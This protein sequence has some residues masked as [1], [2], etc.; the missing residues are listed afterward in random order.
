MAKV[1]L[2]SCVSKKRSEKSKA[3]DLY[4]SPLFKYNLRYAQSMHPD[5]IFILSAEYGL[6]DLDQEVAPYN[7]TLNNMS[8]NEIKIWAEE[9]LLK[10]KSRIEIS[11]DEVVFLAGERYRKFL[12]PHIARY[13]VPMKGLGIGKQLHYLKEKMKNE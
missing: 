11:K 6:L 1:V 9:V 13:S 8:S 3:K 12:I 10:L 7:K 4:T 2:I 5:K